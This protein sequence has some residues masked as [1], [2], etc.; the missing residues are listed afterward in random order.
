MT[1]LGM[2]YN[3]QGNW[4]VKQRFIPQEMFEFEQMKL[5]S[6]HILIHMPGVEDPVNR[7]AASWYGIHIPSSRNTNPD[8]VSSSLQ[9]RSRLPEASQPA[10]HEPIYLQQ[11]MN[12]LDAFLFA[13]RLGRDRVPKDG[14]CLYHA[15][16]RY[17]NVSTQEVKSRILIM[18]GRVLHKYNLNGGAC[19][20]N[21]HMI[22]E[23]YTANELFLL[24][25]FGVTMLE[26]LND[27][28]NMDGLWNDFNMII[29]A[30]NT[31]NT[32]ILYITPGFSPILQPEHANLHFTQ[33]TPGHEPE[34]LV[35]PPYAPMIFFEA[36]GEPQTPHWELAVPNEYEGESLLSTFAG[37]VKVIGLACLPVA[38]SAF[39]K[40]NQSGDQ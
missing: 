40:V 37:M 17:L 14:S 24:T 31:F 39:T 16:A 11:Y 6:G 33:V 22:S 19:G 38:Y 36:L 26:Q 9:K 18:L 23:P 4:V 27:E 5:F 20:D 28:L 12:N 25:F 21:Q 30:A 1:V 32:P 8:E 10:S 3:E 35:N 2:A 29:L 34:P 7:G 13:A 15:I